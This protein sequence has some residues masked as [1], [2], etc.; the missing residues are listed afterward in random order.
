M[1][2]DVRA[3][4]LNQNTHVMR[5]IEGI[6]DQKFNP[7]RVQGR[8]DMI[9]LLKRA[10]KSFSTDQRVEPVICD[11]DLDDHLLIGVCAPDVPSMNGTYKKK[12]KLYNQFHIDNQ[13]AVL[14]IAYKDMPP[15]TGLL[16]PN[17]VYGNDQY[18]D[19][20]AV[21]S[22]LHKAV[23]RGFKQPYTHDILVALGNY[24][25]VMEISGPKRHVRDHDALVDFL[26]VM[27]PLISMGDLAKLPTRML[28]PKEV[29]LHVKN[30]DFF[31]FYPLV[32]KAYYELCKY[33]HDYGISASRIWSK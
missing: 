4:K 30:G 25:R 8:K 33:G 5:L 6:E 19:T 11:Y 16:I 2:I 29:D 17:A 22:V 28:P 26:K 24:K 1:F 14:A 18:R 9:N 21:L 12:F 15:A 32:L 31:K 3:T 10:Y 27:V 20:N 23:G 13:M 7:E